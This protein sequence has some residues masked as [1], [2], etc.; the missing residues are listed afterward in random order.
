MCLPNTTTT[1]SN[2][3]ASD[4]VNDQPTIE[5]DVDDPDRLLAA[6]LHQVLPRQAVHNRCLLTVRLDL[7]A[8]L[9]IISTIREAY[10]RPPTI[11]QRVHQRS[12][13]PYFLLESP[14]V[15]EIIISSHCD[16]LVV[17]SVVDPFCHCFSMD[18]EVDRIVV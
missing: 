10:T 16:R 4:L 1:V 8:F 7:S 11:I 12:L 2:E 6:N 18:A 9:V 15:A 17:T 3:P 13:L 14:L 5:A